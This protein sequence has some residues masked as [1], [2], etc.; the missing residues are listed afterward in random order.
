MRSQSL[1]LIFVLSLANTA[2]DAAGTTFY[3]HYIAGNDLADGTTPDAPWKHAPGDPEATGRPLTAVLQA[4]DFV[5]FAGG[6]PYRGSVIARFSG[7]PGNPITYS[8][9]G[10]GGSAAIFE[11]ATPV[12]SITPCI[13]A[14]DC[15]DAPAWYK[16]SKVAFPQPTTNFVKFYDNDGLL[17]ESQTPKPLDR[18]FSDSI[19]QFSYSPV[20]E[21]ANIEAG[22]LKAPELVAL[23]AGHTLGQ[24]LIWTAGN[25]VRNFDVTGIDGDYVLFNPDGLVIYGD[26]PGRY[27]HVN[28]PKTISGGGQ[29]AVT[30]PGKA[31]VWARPAGGLRVGTGKFALRL[32]KQSNITVTGFIFRNHTTAA[33][34]KCC[35]G[36]V[37]ASS[38]TSSNLTIDN[39]RF[40]HSALAD[41]KGVIMF[42][43]QSNMKITNNKIYR[44]EHGS[45][46]RA[47]ADNYN[48]TVTNNS[49]DMLGRTAIAFLGVSDGVISDN[50]I[51]NLHGV[52]GNGISLYLN[53]RRI[54]V[55]N[56]RI[57]VTDRPM[58]FHG[59]KHTVAQGDHNFLIERN[60]M[61]SHNVDGSAG[62]I[63]YGANTR[64]VTIRNNVLI[65]PKSGLH[66]NGSDTGVSAN[67]NFVSKIAY[68]PVQGVGWTIADNVVAANTVS[69]IAND[70]VNDAMLCTGAKVPAKV[71]LGRILC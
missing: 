66:L 15:D 21:R 8:G 64:G 70:P 62:L 7:T 14:A 4:G 5:R 1:A 65:G 50:V 29:Y 20:S 46:I 17:Y 51:I 52:H 40:E 23:L 53:N 33:D 44:I 63:S 28:A 42:S 55:I 60:I 2:V 48:L 25:L 59:D 56:N 37:M 26:R 35:G 6:V 58:T 38:T 57:I 47:G 43:G 18:F 67:D 13:S 49:F 9:A 68:Y 34:D 36:T 54:K 11:G 16:L 39:N 24:L 10:Y 61:I 19:E 45:G 12:T 27:A 69:F 41:G 22:R 71:R 30:G 31:I 3:V 32:D